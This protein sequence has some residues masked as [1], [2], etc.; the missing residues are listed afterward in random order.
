MGFCR[1]KTG[2]TSEKYATIISAIYI[3][4]CKTIFLLHDKVNNKPTCGIL[5]TNRTVGI[6]EMFTN[7]NQNYKFWKECNDVDI[8][9]NYGQAC[10]CLFVTT[11]T[12]H[13]MGVRVN[14]PKTEH[15]KE[16]YSAS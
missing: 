4:A 16:S 10:S 1:T 2:P 3:R 5:K 12:R 7:L 13:S 11:P 6:R 14:V 9:P 8:F 15:E